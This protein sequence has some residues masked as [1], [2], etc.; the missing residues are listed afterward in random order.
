MSFEVSGFDWDDGNIKKCRKHGVSIA[1]IENVF[2][3]NPHIAPDS[4]HSTNEKRYIAI[5]LSENNRP[6]FVAFTIRNRNGRLIRP[7]SARF[8]HEKEVRAY[9]KS[10]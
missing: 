8:M 4:K 1:D 2:S 5:G 9:E 7:I 10:S 6:M 3:K